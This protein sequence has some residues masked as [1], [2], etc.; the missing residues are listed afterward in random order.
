MRRFYSSL[1]FKVTAGLLL[2]LLAILS[3]LAYVRHASYQSLLME[4]LQNSAATAGEIIEGSLQ[5]AMLANG[6][7]LV[8][9]DHRIKTAGVATG[10]I[11]SLDVEKNLIEVETDTP[12]TTGEALEQTKVTVHNPHYSRG[13]T[14]PLVSITRLGGSRYQL[15]LGDTYLYPGMGKVTEVDVKANTMLTKVPQSKLMNGRHLYDG[16]WLRLSKRNNDNAWYHIKTTDD[17]FSL[18]SETTGGVTFF[19]DEPGTAG[20]LTPGDVFWVYA[21]APGDTFEV[22]NWAVLKADVR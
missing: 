2:P 11:L 8:I 7:K 1:R 3:M 20:K 9:D 19:F 18:G 13:E 12:M 6:K 4:N 22:G 14:F 15:D 10:K 21:I 5:H 17:R 16:K